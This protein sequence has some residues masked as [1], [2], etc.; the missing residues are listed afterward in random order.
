MPPAYCLRVY[1]CRSYDA[2]ILLITKAR[3]Y[4]KALKWLTSLCATAG[5]MAALPAGASPGRCLLQVGGKYNLN[6]TCNIE[7]SEG[8]S[9]SIGADDAKPS[10]YFAYVEINEGVARGFWNGPVAESHAHEP[11]GPLTRRGACWVN[12]DAKVCAWRAAATSPT[13]IGALTEGFQTSRRKNR[14]YLLFQ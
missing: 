3:G 6:G 8:G 7:H 4:M 10:L 9:F 11:L 2:G 14:R 13:K 1:L 12:K 5:V